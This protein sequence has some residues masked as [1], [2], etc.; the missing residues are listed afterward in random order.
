MPEKQLMVS[1]LEGSLGS[2]EPGSFSKNRAAVWLTG[3]SFPVVKA[4]V[5]NF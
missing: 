5:R 3:L 1:S 2:C 4:E